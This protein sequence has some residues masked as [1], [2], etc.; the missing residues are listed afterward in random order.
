MAV[1]SVTK[2]ESLP[3]KATKNPPFSIKR[4]TINKERFIS[5]VTKR[6][7]EIYLSRGGQPGSELSDWVQ[8]E[9]ELLAEYQIAQ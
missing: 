7:Y 1:K 9:N 4:P 5:E 8:A 6:A 3:K 2:T